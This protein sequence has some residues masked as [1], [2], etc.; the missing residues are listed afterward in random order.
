M[1]R[2]HALF[3]R[4]CALRTLVGKPAPRV[5][6]S[7]AELEAALAE[8]PAS[9]PADATNWPRDVGASGAV[10]DRTKERPMTMKV[11]ARVAAGNEGDIAS[12]YA[13]FLQGKAQNDA[14]A[15]FEPLW[16]PDFLF[17]FRRSLV[18]WSLRM[19]R[20][21]LFED[22]G[23]G[24][25]AQLLTWSQNVVRHTNRPVLVLTPL[26][27]GAQ[28]VSEAEK[29][30]VEAR[31]SLDGKVH[32]AGVYVANYERLHHFNRDDF[33]GVVCDESGILKSFD[34]VT[35]KAVT[36][37]MRPLPYRLLT[38]ATA[39]PNDFIELGTS[40]EALGGLGHVDMLNRF[41]KNDSNT[42][43]VG[44]KFGVGGGGGPA[45][46][47][48]G[49]AEK[50]F[51]RWVAS[52]ARALRRPSD[53]GFEDGRFVLP[54]LTERTH[55]VR[56]IK[57]RD[58]MLFAMPAQGLAEQREE[59]RRTLKERCERAASLV[60]DTGRPAVCW[61]HL[62]DE[63]DLLERLIPGAVQVSGADSDDMKEEKFEAFTRGQA[64]VLVTK[65]SIGAWGMNWQH[66]AHTTTFASHS[67]EQDYQ[68]IRRFW[69]F[70]QAREVVVDRIV[71]DG[72][73][74]VLANLRRKAEQADK[75][76]AELIAHMRDG[77]GVERSGYGSAPVE[78]PSWL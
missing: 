20:S 75:M 41:F 19:G 25:T 58:G 60:A 3:V 28:T 33:A 64:R 27:V 78:V 61:A 40:S 76:F 69:R 10:T 34:G 29:F 70:G 49:H 26:A 63:A 47:F 4:L 17:D 2:E 50:P 77:M 56:S 35:R 48:K 44:R 5:G 57:P 67:F 23:M 6:M 9:A 51:W 66:C 12:A 46:R 32:G 38:T 22:C 31:R 11:Q 54:P 73:D 43:D 36:E 42:S 15:G 72:E 14:R 18:E 24:K 68:C 8:Q 45:W 52:W 71:S 30:G 53:L 13:Q 37:F 59:R 62:N 39:A 1:S 21:A 55:V 65:P 7:I 16:L 74:A